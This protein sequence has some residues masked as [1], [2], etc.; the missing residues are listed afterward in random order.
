M[1]LRKNRM[2]R[3]VSGIQLLK[4][5]DIFVS[6]SDG[7]HTYRIPALVVSTKETILAFCEG[8]KYG[9]GD[10]GKI[11]IVLK[12]SLDGGVTWEDMQT[13]VA[14]GDMTCGNPCPV[15]DQDTGTIWLPFNKNLGD[16]GE[17]LIMEGK[18]PRTVWI[19]ESSD[20][21][22][23]WSE[24]V[25]ITADVKDPS[26]TWYATGPG[27]GIQLRNGRLLMPCDHV[28]GKYL[29]REK[30]PYYSH[31]IYSDDHGDHW[32]L[33]GSVGP[34]INECTVVQTY[35]GSLYLN[36]RNHTAEGIGRRVRSVSWS[37]D[38]GMTWSEVEF[39][40]TLVEP[41]CQA[42]VVRFTDEYNHDKNRVL[43]SNPASQ[44]E[45][46]NMTIRLSYD[47]C[48]TWKVF[49]TLYPG[50]SAYSDLA[51]AADMTI[52]CLY[53]R[54]RHNPYEQITFSSFNIEWVTNGTDRY[55][56]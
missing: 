39:D 34:N 51:I 36:M 22:A 48:K 8:R 31:V 15:V 25:E 43:F 5:T 42:S 38:Y 10:A 53:E 23:T 28:V 19:T 18:G 21:G 44:K 50:P 2:V 54:G 11:D 17:T 37:E 29:S 45:R 35:D 9:R 3:K 13:I 12:R 56:S 27:H 24:P 52:C 30:D 55:K 1:I 33:G 49:K 26:W 32:R 14:D 40:K 46:V 20:D 4:R 7:Y 41:I 16:V 6:G 47:E